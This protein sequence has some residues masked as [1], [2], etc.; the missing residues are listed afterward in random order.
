MAFDSDCAYQ[1]LGQR[2]SS[3]S[4]DSS[5]RGNNDMSS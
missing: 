2:S 5:H 4:A 3:V 1:I